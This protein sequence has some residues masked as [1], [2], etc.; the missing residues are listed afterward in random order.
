M[1]DVRSVFEGGGFDVA[2]D[3]RVVILR[4]ILHDSLNAAAPQDPP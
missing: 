4:D 3:T 2:G 1:S